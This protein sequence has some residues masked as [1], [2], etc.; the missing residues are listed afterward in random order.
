MFHPESTRTMSR[1]MISPRRHTSL[2]K[3]A[4]VMLTAAS[5]TLLGGCAIW[6]KALTFGSDPMPEQAPPP[7]AVAPVEPEAAAAPVPTVE[8]K[9][10][11]TVTPVAE[12]AAAEPAPRPVPPAVA[13]VAPPSPLPMPHKAAAVGTAHG[14]YVNAG[15][16]AIPANGNRAYEKLERAGLPV[17]TEVVQTSRGQRTRVRVGPY[18]TKAK[19]NVAAGKV[20]ALKLDANV[21][22]H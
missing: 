14:Y 18:P 19:A 17:F 9:S 10:T 20:R 15:L 22:K 1:P 2:R 11:P 3:G 8:V 5:V 16:F 4:L 7:P 21:I 12:P 13:P 6:P